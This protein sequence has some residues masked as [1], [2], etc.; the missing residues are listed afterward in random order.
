MLSWAI[1]FLLIGAVGFG[2]IAVAAAGVAKFLFFLFMVM[3]LISF[4]L[5]MWQEE[6]SGRRQANQVKRSV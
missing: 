6:E 2:G 3:G 1:I 5:C 4:V